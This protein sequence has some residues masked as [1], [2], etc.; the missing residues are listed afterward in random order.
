MKDGIT[1]IIAMRPE[2]RAGRYVRK[3]QLGTRWLRKSRASQADTA[4]KKKILMLATNTSEIRCEV[5]LLA[6][7]AATCSSPAA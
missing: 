1:G 3:K 6:A 2:S 5:E 4:K 7:R